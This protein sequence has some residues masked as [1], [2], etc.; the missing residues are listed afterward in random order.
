MYFGYDILFALPCIGI[1]LLLV[2]SFGGAKKKILEIMQG[3]SF[4]FTY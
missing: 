1:I 4:A 3:H 2:F